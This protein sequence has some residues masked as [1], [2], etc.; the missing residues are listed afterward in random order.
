MSLPPLVMPRPLSYPV[1]D[2]HSFILR[3]HCFS[4][5]CHI[6][7][8]TEC[9]GGGKIENSHTYILKKR[10]YPSLQSLHTPHIRTYT[11]IRTHTPTH[12]AWLG[13]AWWPG[14]RTNA[15]PFL[16]SPLI[17][18]SAN[19]TTDPTAWTKEKPKNFLKIN[20]KWIRIYLVL[21]KL[22]DL[23]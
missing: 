9:P 20:V 21:L 2:D 15:N 14:G 18:L 4:S 11:H 6:V 3:D 16:T 10:S 1:H 12:M 13:R 23:A 19:S 8:I 7:E 5:Y 17:I 22:I